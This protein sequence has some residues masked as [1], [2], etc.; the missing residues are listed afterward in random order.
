MGICLGHRP[1]SLKQDDTVRVVSDEGLEF[2]KSHGN[3]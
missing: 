3:S 2:I 1:A